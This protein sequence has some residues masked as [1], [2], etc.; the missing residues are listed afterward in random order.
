MRNP[1][2]GQEVANF[3][4][5]SD[6][7]TKTESEALDGIY[8]LVTSPA[9]SNPGLAERVASQPWI[10]D[11]ITAI[12]VR[13]LLDLRVL[14][15]AAEQVDSGLA[16]RLASHSWIGDS[17]T[18]E[19]LDAL[20]WFEKLLSVAQES[21]NA[22]VEA[23]AGFSWIADGVTPV[24]QEH[25][26]SFW[27]LL[28]NSRG[29]E[30]EFLKKLAT[31]SWID[32]AL[33]SQD[34]EAAGLLR[35][36]L[37]AA[38]SK[39][40][41]LAF[42]VMDYSWVA[43]GISKDELDALHIFPYLLRAAGASNSAIVKEV[44]S[45]PW[46]T[47]GISFPEPDAINRFRDLIVDD[48]SADF[49]VAGAVAGYEW[50][51]DGVT[52]H[53]M[54]VL[55]A[56]WTL[57]EET[58]A[59]DFG[60]IE[61]IAGYS[62]MSDGVTREELKELNSFRSS[63]STPE[64]DADKTRISGSQDTNSLT[65]S[66]DYPWISDGITRDELESARLLGQL[67]KA[68]EAAGMEA[69]SKVDSYPWISDGITG[70]EMDALTL[71]LH[72]FDRANAAHSDVAVILSAYPW[73][74]DGLSGSE[75]DALLIFQ[76]LIDT[77]GTENTTYAENV[78]SYQWVADSIAFREPD[79]IN[80]LRDVL[81]VTGQEH[82]ELASVIGGYHWVADGLDPG[83]TDA[84]R[85]IMELITVVGQTDLNNPPKSSYPWIT[86]CTALGL[87]ESQ[88]KLG[89]LL[90]SSDGF[91]SGLLEE[92]IAAPWV[93][94]GVSSEERSSIFDIILFLEPLNAVD[95]LMGER[96]SEYPWSPSG[97]SK[98]E[99]SALERLRALLDDPDSGLI[100][101]SW[102]EDG[103][104]HE[105]LAL[106]SVLHET[107]QRSVHQYED[108]LESHHFRSKTIS[109]PLAGD[110]ELLVIRHS[111]FPGLDES[112]ELMEEIARV[113]EEFIGVP[114]PRTRVVLGIIE[115]SLTSGEEVE[116]GL[117]YAH[118][119]QLAITPWEYN[120]DFRLAVYHEMSHIYWGG[121][122][123]APA[124]FNEGAAGFLPDYVRDVLGN[125]KISA[126]RV[127]LHQVWEDEC[128][129]WGVGTV[130]KFLALSDVDPERYESRN[131][132]TYALGEF[133]LLE[134]YQLF[135]R[136][137]AS[138]AMRQLYLESE[139]TGWK[140]PITEEQIYRVYLENAPP[141][142]VEAFLALYERYHGGTYGDG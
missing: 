23:A 133:F 28:E 53:E 49:R 78:A 106:L 6:C 130:S 66:L 39:H 40:S 119:D 114:F 89:E 5:I 108:L 13:V 69:D 38:G 128:R 32:D 56:L 81:M 120:I 19:D 33:T 35:D 70:T 37:E 60:I 137:A 94:D 99:C 113:L 42:T 11:G 80:F 41:A 126:R 25:L 76:T 61:E 55:Y 105:E 87:H 68:E 65:E 88:D 135:G 127:N 111:E 20:G 48:E 63:E 123:G 136:R 82:P 1:Y 142:Q 122:N 58:E 71:L 101:V 57:M 26:R 52:A 141:G 75:S 12:E 124:W 29:S 73:V 77:A 139:A 15:G 100:G 112:I 132:C 125:Q 51:A 14:L 21:D 85:T 93:T 116:W 72:L 34:W 103:L 109:L 79:N 3:H 140:E 18:N 102:F 27:L 9:S 22:F 107:R 62:W 117:G 90:L 16:E 59:K 8:Q 17:I 64:G 83:E 97:V 44:L 98:F 92:T 67:L 45:Y 46:I 36:S 50:L 86:H 84:L 91:Q 47:D 134:T 31:Y 10:A 129:V 138:A 115:P 95:A 121:H 43:D 104:D 74:E 54:D 96:L 131:I 2:L 30:S 110:V 24:E 118:L 4:W 7:I